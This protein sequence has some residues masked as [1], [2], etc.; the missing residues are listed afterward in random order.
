MGQ[1]A[2]IFLKDAKCFK[3]MQKILKDAERFKKM[4]K[5]AKCFKKMQKN[6]NE[7]FPLNKK[8]PK[9]ISFP[10]KNFIPSFLTK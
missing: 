6:S 2:E 9:N 10:L 7:K 5:H 3:M 8:N 4:Q 1:D